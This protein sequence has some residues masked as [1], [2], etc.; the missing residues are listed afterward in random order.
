MNYRHAYHAGNFADV[1]KHAVLARL[2]RRLQAKDT[3]FR[4]IDT[5]AGTGLY[6]LA[7]PEAEKTA[8]WQGGIGR[9]LESPLPADLAE[10]LAPFLDVVRSINND[11]PLRL[12]PGSPLVA[13]RLLRR[14][15][16]LTAVELHP[17]DA[18]LL[19]RRFASD[20]QV[21]IVELDGWLALGSFL[22]PKERRGLV[23][24]DP[25]F[26]AADEFDRLASGFIR[27]HRRWPTGL[28]ALW[29]PLKDLAA[30]AAFHRRLAES[31][32]PR[33][34]I[35]EM[36]VAPPADGIFHGS[37]MI[38]ANPPWQFDEELRLMLPAL[39][40]ILAGGNNGAA[41]VSLLTG[42]AAP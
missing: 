7:G 25:P 32:I 39:A 4:V 40:R 35:A 1:A 33:L 6:D 11:G 14:R 12:Y 36:I 37:G 17:E 41:R 13:R 30:V 10:W 22:P 8:E 18:K 21:R 15:D 3:A 29:Y 16:R 5:H 38:L 9:L 24:V 2:M 27:A 23:L 26:E 19:A 31:G 28:Y 20:I 42:E 34:L